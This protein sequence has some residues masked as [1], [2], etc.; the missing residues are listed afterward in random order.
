MFK[1]GNI[2]RV[3]C[4]LFNQHIKSNI[5]KVTR[6]GEDSSIIWVSNEQVLINNEKAPDGEW[7]VLDENLEL[8]EEYFGTLTVDEIINDLN[9]AI[10]CGKV[11]SKVETGVRPNRYNKAKIP[12]W[13]VFDLLDLDAFQSNVLKYTYRYKDKDGAQDLVKAL[14]YTLKMLSLQIGDKYEDLFKMTIEEL[15]NKFKK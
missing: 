15:N 7:S 1:V 10:V 4:P 5:A 2:V 14:N 9:K 3:K 6:I 12:L 11:T 13:D 8:I